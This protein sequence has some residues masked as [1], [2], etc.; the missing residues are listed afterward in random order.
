MVET[1]DVAIVGAG[2]V[3]TAIA[4]ELARYELSCALIDAAADI[5]SG[6]SKANTAILHT[7]FD[8]KADTLEARLVR[9]GHQLLNHYGA[10]LGIPI[11][12]VGALL[13]AWD[14]E[15]LAALPSIA[16]AAARNGY[17]AARW[18][19]RD[20]LYRR[21]PHLGAGALGALEIADESIIC[22]FTPPLA[23]ATQAVVNGVQ[24]FL[25]APVGAVTTDTDGVHHLSTPRATIRSRWLVNAAGL[26]SDSIDRLLGHD[27]FTVTPRRGELIVF[28]KLARP[29]LNHILLQV[30]TK[31]SKGVLVSPT[32]FGNVLLG[33][34][35]V[36]IDDRRATA[37]TASGLALL[38]ERGAR[39]LPALA[40][41]EVTAVYVGL[42]AATEHGDY[43]IRFRPQQRYACV[44][45]IRSTGL[46]ASMAIAEHVVEGLRDAG[47]DLSRQRELRSVRMPNIGEARLRPY[48]DAAA[49]AANPDYGRVLCHCERVTRGEI[50]DATHAVIP[51]RS[52]DALRRRTRAL[53][54][55]CQGFYCMA[56][57][58]NVVASEMGCSM[59]SLLGLGG[60]PAAR[61]SG[62][63]EALVESHGHTSKDAK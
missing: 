1:F 9:R 28:D 55:R 51:A 5:G 24:L 15:Q 48:Q 18:V 30:P 16:D 61:P 59:E 46:S 44:G 37:S 2:V 8:A 35:A 60:R 34:T 11:E 36:D 43:Q 33:P 41:E 31:L 12:P 54:G 20:E 25:E 63:A 19:G 62:D 27:D 32:V 39:I 7:G 38:Q 10:E 26:Y 4:R 6:T 29:L 17:A 45:G 42:R 53:L 14:D 13:I 57:V 52:L 22:P 3:G 47:L 23:F 56:E 21:E 50:V 40:R 49:I 58:A